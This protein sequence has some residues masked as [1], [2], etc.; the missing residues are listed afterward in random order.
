MALASDTP[1]EKANDG[2]HAGGHGGHGHGHGNYYRGRYAGKYANIF[3]VKNKMLKF[4]NSRDN[5][6][7]VSGVGPIMSQ[8]MQHKVAGTYGK[9]SSTRYTF[10]LYWAAVQ[11]HNYDHALVHTVLVAI[12]ILSLVVSGDKVKS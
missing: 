9:S 5:L 3:S 6:V 10:M 7:Q 11:P 1:G 12:A 8:V 4:E 2:Y